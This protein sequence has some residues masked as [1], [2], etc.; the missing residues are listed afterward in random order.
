[1]QP[2]EVRTPIGIAG[3]NL[4]VEHC[5]F[6][7]ELVQQLCDGRKALGEVM[8]IAAVDDHARAHLVD[9]YAVAVELHLMQPAVAGR[10]G[11]GADRTAG[12][13][14]AQRGHV[15][16]CSGIIA[17]DGQRKHVAALAAQT[18]R[19]FDHI[20]RERGGANPAGRYGTPDEVGAYVAFLCSAHAGFVTG[21]NLLID[22]GQ[23]P[24]TF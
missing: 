23:Y 24:G 18:G 12:L 3:Y 15:S 9:L 6:G 20:W 22:G 1:M 11:C 5:R 2:G 16:G 7:W 13:N 14:E 8:P 17:S 21:Q 19:S 4:A 10:H